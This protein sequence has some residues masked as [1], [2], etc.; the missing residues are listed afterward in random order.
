MA[1][2][3]KHP[4]RAIPQLEKMIVSLSKEVQNLIEK[5]EESSVVKVTG[6]K[7]A[8]ETDFRTGN[9]NLTPANIGAVNKAG[10]VMTGDLTMQGFS[11]NIKAPNT[12]GGWARGLLAQNDGGSI[13][14]GMGYYGTPA[15]AHAFMGVGTSPWGAANGL[16]VTAD[17][18]KW[19][20]VSL[21]NA[22]I[23][24]AG[25]LPI[26]RGGTGA[27]TAAAALAA[28]GGT[29][30][31]LKWSNASHTSNFGAQTVSVS[32]SGCTFALIV[33][34]GKTDNSVLFG[35]LILVGGSRRTYYMINITSDATN[36]IASRSAAVSTTGV[37]F[38]ACQYKNFNG[39]TVNTGNGYLIP[40]RIYGID[41]N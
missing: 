23:L 39:T 7:G 30:I 36:M 17:D 14:A 21:R 41:I 6:V 20:N 38:T 31:N 8:K 35:E 5:I 40:Y 2:D 34:K 16:T 13:I 3:R 15:F 12:T 28:L 26:A 4:D 32:L 1:L 18:I 29:E 10:D 25:T 11:V 24:N 9:V 27:T 22:S 33:Y 19:K 37:T